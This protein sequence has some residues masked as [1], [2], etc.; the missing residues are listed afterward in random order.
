MLKKIFV[1]SVVALKVGLM[2]LAIKTVVAD[3]P[4][5]PKMLADCPSCAPPVPPRGCLRSL[6]VAQANHI[7]SIRCMPSYVW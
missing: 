5:E 7:E 1:A 4:Q 3:F 6:R 2:G